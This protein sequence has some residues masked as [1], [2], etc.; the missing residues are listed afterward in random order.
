MQTAKT[1][2]KEMQ[3]SGLDAASSAAG[4]GFAMTVG[5]PQGQPLID[6]NATTT[7]SGEPASAA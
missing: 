1:E 2:L 7:T 5:L 3:I 6:L 4:S